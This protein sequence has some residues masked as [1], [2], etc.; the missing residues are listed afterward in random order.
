MTNADLVKFRFIH[1]NTENLINNEDLGQA[2]ICGLKYKYIGQEGWESLPSQ[3]WG[4]LSRQ[5]GAYITFVADLPPRW[6]QD[7]GDP[8]R[9][10]LIA[11]RQFIRAI[12]YDQDTYTL[13]LTLEKG[14]ISSA[15]EVVYL[16]GISPSEMVRQIFEH[17]L[18]HLLPLCMESMIEKTAYG[19]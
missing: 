11:K 19:S 14:V 1:A 17:N 13:F 16:C 4:V 12:E 2:S 7:A 10:G 3:A 8:A 15:S 5:S 18:D 9:Y 6:I